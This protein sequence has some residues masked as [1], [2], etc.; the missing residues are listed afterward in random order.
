[1][2]RFTLMLMTFLFLFSCSNDTDNGE[3]V[4]TPEPELSVEQAIIGNWVLYEGLRNG[5]LTSTL[6][7]TTF[8][9]AAN[10]Q[11]SSNMNM[12]G[13][14]EQT[15]YSIADKTIAQRGGKMDTDYVIDHIT[16]DSLTLST[17][18]LNRFNFKLKMLRDQNAENTSD[19]NVNTEEE[20]Q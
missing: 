1:M 7:G 16:A 4:E 9:F 14:M 17:T 3:N 11:L 12:T 10:N 18:L 13:V 15:S 8:Q 2:L 20:L 6:E 5:K 19:T